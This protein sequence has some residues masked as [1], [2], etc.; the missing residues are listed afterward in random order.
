[1]KMQWETRLEDDEIAYSIALERDRRKRLEE[2]IDRIV[3]DSLGEQLDDM[4]DEVVRDELAISV[5]WTID[6][7]AVTEW[8]GVAPDV[9]KQALLVELA[10]MEIA[11]LVVSE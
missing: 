2:A 3:A 5:F 10:E 8:S 7:E 6:L 9:L 1:M 11:E 4:P